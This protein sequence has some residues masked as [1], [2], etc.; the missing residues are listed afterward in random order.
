M[1]EKLTEDAID[2]SKV[3]VSNNPVKTVKV[4]QQPEAKHK[5]VGHIHCLPHINDG[6]IRKIDDQIFI[7]DTF[8]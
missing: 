2:F 8:Q 1:G 7:F 5:E 3:E 4:G 6:V